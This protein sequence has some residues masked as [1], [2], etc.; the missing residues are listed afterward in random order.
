MNNL[1][2]WLSQMFGS[3]SIGLLL[4]QPGI[5]RRVR[6]FSGWC[7]LLGMVFIVH[8][9]AYFYQKYAYLIGLYAINANKKV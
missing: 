7:V 3:V 9:W 4:D 5:R 1:V 2:Y 6:A 8:I